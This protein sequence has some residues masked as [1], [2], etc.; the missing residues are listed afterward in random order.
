MKWFESVFARSTFFWAAARLET[1]HDAILHV[2][3]FFSGKLITSGSTLLVGWPLGARPPDS[4]VEVLAFLLCDWDSWSS[5]DG[6]AFRLLVDDA[7]RFGG[8]L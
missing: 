3:S 2:P 6:E 4:G 5:S 1:F 7:V 8:I